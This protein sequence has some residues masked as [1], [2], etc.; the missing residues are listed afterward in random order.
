MIA[1]LGRGRTT[2]LDARGAQWT[3]KGILFAFTLLSIYSWWKWTQSSKVKSH[4]DLCV[5]WSATEN[6]ISS[7]HW[8]AAEGGGPFWWGRHLSGHLHCSKGPDP[9]RSGCGCPSGPEAWLVLMG[10]KD[11]GLQGLK[12]CNESVPEFSWNV[13]FPKKCDTK[14]LPFTISFVGEKECY[15]AIKK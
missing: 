2:G 8:M 4:Q 10:V 6:K 5:Q 1:A 3:K 12:D 14:K 9:W 7:A 11:S 13:L 15:W